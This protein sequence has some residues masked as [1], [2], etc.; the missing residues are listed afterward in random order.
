MTA[1]SMCGAA[2]VVFRIQ[3]FLGMSIIY[4]IL[5]LGAAMVILHCM[6]EEAE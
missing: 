4:A 6:A 1:V 3:G 2:A 5:A